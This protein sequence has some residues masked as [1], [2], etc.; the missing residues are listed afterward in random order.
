[1]EN[2]VQNVLPPNLS[3]RALHTYRGFYHT[4]REFRH[5]HQA[6]CILHCSRHCLV[7]TGCDGAV[8]VSFGEDVG[9]RDGVND[10]A[11]S[12]VDVDGACEFVPRGP[13][14]LS[15]AHARWADS[16]S[17]NRRDQY[18][19]HLL[20]GVTKFPGF[21]LRIGRIKMGK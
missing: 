17:H 16:V 20:V 1:M 14:G 7:P 8:S 21:R 10:N 3:G 18:G 9:K 15:G 4:S 2:Q 19:A 5:V 6:Y 12:R 11:E 13:L